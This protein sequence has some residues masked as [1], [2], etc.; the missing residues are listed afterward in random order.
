MSIN[1]Y[2]RLN[3]VLQ[4]YGDNAKSMMLAATNAAEDKAIVGKVTTSS[5]MASITGALETFKV[6]L[7]CVF[8]FRILSYFYLER[9][10][11]WST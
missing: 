9:E 8:L 7:S 6:R 2:D 1:Q 4:Q 11:S 10:N 3:R 5:D